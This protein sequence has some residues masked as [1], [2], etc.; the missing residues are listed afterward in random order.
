MACRRSIFTSSCYKTLTDYLKHWFDI[1][2]YGYSYISSSL[3]C[4]SHPSLEK[5]TF[6]SLPTQANHAPSHGYCSKQYFHRSSHRWFL[7]WFWPALHHCQLEFTSLGNQ[8]AALWT[9][10]YINLF[11]SWICFRCSAYPFL[12]RLKVIGLGRHWPPSHHTLEFFASFKRIAISSAVKT[13][14]M[15]RQYRVLGSTY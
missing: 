13:M 1:G 8:P 3:S 14:S 6:C 2:I 4:F 7:D 15:G 9:S 11:H 5:V 10:D 12:F